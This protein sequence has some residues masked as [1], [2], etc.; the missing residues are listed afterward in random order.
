MLPDRLTLEPIARFQG[1]L[2]LPGSKSL[3]NRILLLSA[4][5]DGETEATRVLDSEDT[6]VMLSALRTLGVGVRGSPGPR[7][8]VWIAG[9]GGALDAPSRPVALS[10]GNA[11][12]AMRPLTAV[13]AAGHGD[14]T[15]SGAPR[16]H[17]RPIGDL[18]HGLRQLGARVTCLEREGYPPLR[19]EA[20]GLAGGTA[21]I[22]G[23]T[24]SQFLSA[25]LM[26]APLAGGPV[27]LEITDRLV[28]EP[29]VDMTLALMARFGAVV[30][31]PAPLRFEIAAPRGYRSPG[32]V[33]V[34][35][36]ASSASYFLAGAAITGGKVRVEGCGSDSL[37][38]DARF[39]E[40]LARMGAHA[41]FEPA[42]IEVEGGGRLAGIDADLTAMPDAAMTLAVASL[43][44]QG[45]TTVRGIGNWRVK[46]TD[47]M[48]AVAAEL[49]KLGAR[50]EIGADSL[51]VHPPARIRAASIATYDDHRM[52][53]AFSLAACGGERVV[54]EN[55]ACVAKTFPEYF[56]E[57]AHLTVPA[58]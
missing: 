40:V 36:D 30:E 51:T 27:T 52:A 19:L 46:E 3:S 35:G 7:G 1:T 38:G 24:S 4:L 50:T 44:A 37:Q 11:G 43:F 21:R 57:L 47:R 5:A 17:E 26:A 23:A 48:A 29:Y 15:L 31:R 54:I 6:E 18:L 2:E 34:E 25:L 14:F 9:R 42:A 28:S 20:A 12:T 56:E 53:M 58:S 41:R 13:L 8:S 39:A 45:P 16:M 55:P 10:L 22:S 33:L 32:R 49:G